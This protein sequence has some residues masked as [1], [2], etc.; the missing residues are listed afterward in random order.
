MFREYGLLTYLLDPEPARLW[1]WSGGPGAAPGSGRPPEL[2]DLYRPEQYGT[3]YAQGLTAFDAQDCPAARRWLTLAIRADPPR[4]DDARYFHAVC[5]YRESDWTA[6][7]AEFQRL[8]EKRPATQWQAAAHWHMAM[9]F[10]ALGDLTA[11]RKQFH[12][13]LDRFPDDGPLVGLSNRELASL[14][15]QDRGLIGMWLDRLGVWWNG[16]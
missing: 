14:G 15:R 9:S 7:I 5:R 3:L 10:K 8:A 1:R 6:A 4:A 2:K 12:V 13:V 11:A 16:D